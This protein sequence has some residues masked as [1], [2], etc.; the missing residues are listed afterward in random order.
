MAFLYE[1]R[2]TLIDEQG[3]KTTLR[4]DLG[5][6]IGTDIAT[7]I[8]PVWAELEAIGT[9][10]DVITTANIFRMELG[11][12]DDANES[13]SLPAEAEVPEEAAV[14][15]HLTAEP[16]AEKL[17]YLRIPAPVDALFLADGVTVDVNNADLQA[18]IADVA[19]AEVS[20]GETIV[21]AR[22]AGGM[23]KG[24]LRFKARSGRT[25]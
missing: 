1:G 11:F 22:G 23:K 7:E 20:D 19:V 3:L 24:H 17:H 8:G 12:R 13:S 2:I 15:V 16:E 21:V 14:A 10:L 9:T 18:Y 4:Y 6:T 25:I 5:T